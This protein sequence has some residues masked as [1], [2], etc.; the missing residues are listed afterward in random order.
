MFFVTRDNKQG[1]NW[2]NWWTDEWKGIKDWAERGSESDTTQKTGERVRIWGRCL[3]Q[4]KF[5][6]MRKVDK[7]LRKD[8]QGQDHSNSRCYKPT[9]SKPNYC[10]FSTRITDPCACTGWQGPGEVSSPS[11]AQSRSSQGVK[12]G[13]SGLHTVRA[14]NS[15]GRRHPNFPGPQLHLWAVL[16]GNRVLRISSLSLSCFSLCRCLSPSLHAL[17]WRA[18]LHL[19]P[20]SPP[21]SATDSVGCPWSHPSSQLNQPWSHKLSSQGK[22]SSPTTLVASSHLQPVCW[23]LSCTQGDIPDVVWWTQCRGDPQAML[24]LV[25]AQVHGW[26]LLSSLPSRAI[27]WSCSLA[28][29]ASACTLQ[30]SAFLGKMFW[31]ANFC[32]GPP[33]WQLC[34]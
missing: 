11:P 20:S 10:L 4:G 33:G 8:T 17:L 18:Q 12:P 24:S 15:A 34:P 31:L 7:Y 27:P 16:L 30:G 19:P 5:F 13:C 25:A 29:L 6:C 3:H 21:V 14:W 9:Q 28:L 2:L 22:G 26:P 32:Q 1:M 23:C